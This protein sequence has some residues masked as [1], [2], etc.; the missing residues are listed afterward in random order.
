MFSMLNDI[1]SACSSLEPFQNLNL[2]CISRFYW[3]QNVEKILKIKVWLQPLQMLCTNQLLCT[4]IISH[5]SHTF[6]AMLTFFTPNGSLLQPHKV[7][8]AHDYYLHKLQVRF[9]YL[10]IFL[11]S[12]SLDFFSREKYFYFSTAYESLVKCFLV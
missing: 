7:M 8:R 6:F 2:I 10:S 4:T 9:Q 12:N 11:F 1:K 3:N 5:I